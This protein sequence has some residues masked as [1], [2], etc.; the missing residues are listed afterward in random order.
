MFSL[1]KI[2]KMED[3]PS[4]PQLKKA[5]KEAMNLT[6]MGVTMKKAPQ[7]KQRPRFPDTFKLLY[8]RILKHLCSLKKLPLIQKGVYHMDYR[9]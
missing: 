9:C 6:D 7:P 2:T 8:R 4:K 1:G 3:L 5:I